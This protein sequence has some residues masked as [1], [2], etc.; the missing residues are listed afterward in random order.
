MANVVKFLFGLGLLLAGALLGLYG[1]FAIH[2][3]GEGGGNGD[4]YVKLGGHEIDADVAG[5]ISLLLG[6]LA[7]FASILFLARRRPKAQR[8]YDDRSE[9]RL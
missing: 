6:F 1:L 4:L 7:T 5:A 2:Y 9:H 8:A 3:G